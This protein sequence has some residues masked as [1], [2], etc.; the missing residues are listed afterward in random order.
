MIGGVLGW[1]NTYNARNSG[2]KDKLA[3]RQVLICRRRV[4]LFTGVSSNEST[5]FKLI[6]LSGH[7]SNFLLAVSDTKVLRWTLKSQ[8]LLI[9][10]RHSFLIDSFGL[11]EFLLIR[12]RLSCRV[13]ETFLISISKIN[14]G[15]IS[16]VAFVVG[17]KD[18]SIV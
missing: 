13:T 3:E 1:N 16:L 5:K 6:S 12:T 18:Y 14:T 9:I 10:R 4:C 15:R 7:L 2:S 17:G 8:Y 11:G